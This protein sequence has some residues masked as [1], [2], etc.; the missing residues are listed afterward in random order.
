MW[1]I[2]WL[3]WFVLS[4]FVLAVY[5][6]SMK[7]L[8]E[9][10]EA[11]RKFAE[12]HKLDYKSE[13]LT[14]PPYLTGRYKDH[15]LYVYSGV[16][17]TNDVSGQRFV[18]IIEIELGKGVPVAGAVGTGNLGR[19]I[20]GLNFEQEYAPNSEYWDTAYTLKTRDA[21]LLK[22]YLTEDRLKAL[23]SLF[24]MKNA[25]VLYFFDD[26]ES[27]LR[28]ETPDPL[29]NAGRMEKIFDRIYKALDILMISDQEFKKIEK[30]SAKKSKEKAA[31]EDEPSSEDK[32][33]QA[34]ADK[35]QDKDSAPKEQ[36][37]S[38]PAESDKP[39]SGQA[40]DKAESKEES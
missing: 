21:T 35:D 9:Q 15:R 10:K 20:L 16:Q 39:E 11:W 36:K 31:E 28:I 7:I 22:L 6:W 33:D 30:E 27:V 17:A 24:K 5:G 4:A 34:A 1:T 23:Q 2:F 19:F 18:T 37:K 26:V 40:M 8:F 29:R 3:I 25:S 13:K 14:S 32:Q 12:K 38:G